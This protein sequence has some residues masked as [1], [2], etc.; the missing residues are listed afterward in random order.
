VGSNALLLVG[1]V[2]LFLLAGLA[3]A[4]LGKGKATANKKHAED[5]V[6]GWVAGKEVYEKARHRLGSIL[7]GMSKDGDPPKDV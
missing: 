2:F 7:S 6:R 1:A 4:L 3:W 5:T